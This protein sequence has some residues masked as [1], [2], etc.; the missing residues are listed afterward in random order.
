MIVIIIVFMLMQ[1]NS[2]DNFPRRV[3]SVSSFQLYCLQV[4]SNYGIVETVWAIEHSL[5]ICS[6]EVQICG[7]Y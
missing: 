2:F 5:I 3:L 7:V 1:L 4:K 6:Q